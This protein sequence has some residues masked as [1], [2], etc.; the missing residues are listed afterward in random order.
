MTEGFVTVGDVTF[1]SAAY[2]ARYILKKE[3]NKE[4]M[5]DHYC[6]INFAT[7]ESYRIIPEYTTMSRRPGI[8]ASFVDKYFTDIDNHDSVVILNRGEMRPPKYYD[9]LFQHNY[10]I[11]MT[12]VKESRVQEA[13][14]HEYDQTPWRLKVKEKVKLA[15]ISMLKRSLE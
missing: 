9:Y 8:G 1:E 15:A 13:K 6:Y 11:D 4:K 12:E 7:G 10:G 2:V 5:D 3:N 14:K